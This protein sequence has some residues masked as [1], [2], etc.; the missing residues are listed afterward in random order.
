MK[1]KTRKNKVE[2][3]EDEEEEVVE[4][5]VEEVIE[6]DGEDKSWEKKSKKKSKSEDSENDGEKLQSSDV[7]RLERVQRRATKMI[8]GLGSL[9]YEERLR[10]LGLFSLDKRRLRGDLITIFQYLKGGYKEDG[11]SLFTRSHMKKTRVTST[12]QYGRLWGDLIAAFQYLKRAYKKDGERLFTKACSDMT[13]GNGFKLK[14]SRFRLD[15]RKKFFTMR[16]MRHWNRLPREFVD[17]PSL[18]VFR[19]RLDRALSNLI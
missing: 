16:V 18:K 15:I 14:D 4:E 9:P 13:R 12:V 8:K 10:E 17:A 7:D 3:E 19:V 6:E 11:D 5:V 1:E 2:E